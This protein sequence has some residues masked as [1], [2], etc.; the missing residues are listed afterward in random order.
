MKKACKH[1]ISALLIAL[2]ALSALCG[3]GGSPKTYTIEQGDIT[4]ESGQTAALSLAN[5]EEEPLE[6]YTS[7]ASIAYVNGKGVVTGVSYGSVTVKAKIGDV[8]SEEINVTVKPGSDAHYTAGTPDMYS[9]AFG[10]Y[11]MSF[12]R[13]SN[14]VPLAGLNPA[15]FQ[16][17]DPDR[18]DWNL[19][20]TVDTFQFWLPNITWGKIDKIEHTEIKFDKNGNN[21]K[22]ITL[23]VDENGGWMQ[24]TQNMQKTYIND[25]DKLLSHRARSLVWD[26][27]R[28]QFTREVEGFIISQGDISETEGVEHYVPTCQYALASNSGEILPVAALINDLI[29]TAKQGGASANDWSE[30]P[31]NNYFTVE[32]NV[33]HFQYVMAMCGIRIGDTLHHGSFAFDETSGR[34]AYLSMD[35]I[36]AK[37]SPRRIIR[38]Y[39]GEKDLDASQPQA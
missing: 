37:Q 30:A 10:I 21:S 33:V 31:F 25:P 6:W 34:L 26:D 32:N 18:E 13:S 27:S 17:D 36:Y 9:S 15:L 7:D 11:L 3:C 16:Y 22:V 28:L 24:D 23:Y 20:M 19:R 12:M 35:D 5:T 38:F 8:W 4:L 1:G 29:D 2:F 14:S 39:Y